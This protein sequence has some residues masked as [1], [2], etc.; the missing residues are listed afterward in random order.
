MKDISAIII[1]K[2]EEE[3]IA[4]CLDSVSFCDEIILVDNEST[5]RTVEIAKHMGA[6]VVKTANPSFAEKRNIGLSTAKGKWVLY[7]DADERVT[8]ALREEIQAVLANKQ[9][10][11]T[12]YVL[13]R[14]DFVYGNHEWPY[15]GNMERLFKRSTLKEW[16]GALHETPRYEGSLGELTQFLNHFTR[17]SITQMVN[18]TIMWSET[19]AQ[20]RIDA[21]HP[22]MTWWR[23]PRVMMTAFFDSYIRQKGYKSGVAGIVESMYQMYSM[24]ITYARLWEKQQEKIV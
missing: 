4:D 5:D 17:R 3:M 21:K 13:P 20:L 22:M 16:Y 15:I 23:F 18:K 14:K 7:I 24:F 6:V 12:A 1:A 8:S 2:N 10:E 19:E 9:S 11:H